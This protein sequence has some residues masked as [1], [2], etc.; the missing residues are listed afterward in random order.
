LIHSNIYRLDEKLCCEKC[1]FDSGQHAEFCKVKLAQQLTPQ[2]SRVGAH[3]EQAATN[4][5]VG[6][7]YVWFDPRTDAP[8]Y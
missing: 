4:T 7:R 2:A 1:A 5:V 6:Q 3:A 8:F